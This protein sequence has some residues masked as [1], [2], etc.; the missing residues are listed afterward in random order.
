MESLVELFVH[1]DDFCQAFLPKL[2]QDLLQSG[3]I[4]RR[5]ARS[6]SLS[7]VL[8]ILIHF[9]QS[10]SRNFKAYYCEHVLPHLRREFPGLISYTVLSI[11]FLLCWSHSAFPSSRPAWA[12]APVTPSS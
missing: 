7:E 8:T 11:S 4:Q 10:H 3:A 6:L 12:T 5:R 2:E 1:V 9:H